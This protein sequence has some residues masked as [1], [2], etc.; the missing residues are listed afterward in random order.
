[1]HP[2]LLAEVERLENDPQ[3][4]H[5]REREEYRRQGRARRLT[6]EALRQRIH[7]ARPKPD[8]TPDLE[9]L[10]AGLQRSPVRRRGRTDEAPAPSQ[11]VC[12]REEP[13]DLRAE[14]EWQRSHAPTEDEHLDL[15]DQ[16]REVDRRLEQLDQPEPEE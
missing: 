14:L 8:K 15:M 7:R 6:G 9:A 13:E 4:Q 2:I 11:A 5:E 10:K 1:M 12:A 3:F 16:R